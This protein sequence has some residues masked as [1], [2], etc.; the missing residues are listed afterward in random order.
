[1]MNRVQLCLNYEHGILLKERIIM[2]APDKESVLKWHTFFLLL[3]MF[4]VR[5][6]KCLAFLGPNHNWL[7][8]AHAG[9]FSSSVLNFSVAKAIDF[10]STIKMSQFRN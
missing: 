6:S 7:E 4:L 3:L 5:I 8:K 1:M 10:C 9:R 2:L